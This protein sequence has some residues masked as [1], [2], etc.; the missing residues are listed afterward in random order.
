MFFCGDFF[1]ASTM[2][3]ACAP[4]SIED[5]TRVEL[6]NG[7]YDDLRFTKNVEEELSARIPQDWDWD[8]LFHAKFDDSTS[9]GNVNWNLDT[10]SHVLI[11][12][13]KA[14]EFK[15]ITLKVQATRT[16][17]DFNLRDIDLTATPT[18]EY[19]Y[20]AVPIIEG[21]EG[22]YSIDNV[23]VVADGVVIA[24]RDEIW[25]TNITDNYLDNTSV[26]PNSVVETMY[27]R[28]PTIVCNSE[29]NYEQITV[30]AQFIPFEGE[31]AC[32]IVEDVG[33]II[34]YN[35]KAKMF[36]R[37]KNI[38]LLKSGSGENWLVFVT[39]PPSDSA[40]DHY[41]NR[42]LT[43]TCTEVGNVENEEDLWEAGLIHESV[44][45]NWWNK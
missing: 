30:N 15:W 2:S 8:T 14:N 21:V 28:Y 35:R 31:N 38:K 1:C 22:F 45:E 4:T 5:I 41:A 11:K 19:Q 36:L 27:D 34:N 37:N 16:L 40:T 18:N 33:K 42:K 7:W 25:H 10:V 23:E 9:A 43:F 12:R 44:T 29:A 32:E 24:D 13:K 26:V 6:S 20:A 17:E 39:T 3:V